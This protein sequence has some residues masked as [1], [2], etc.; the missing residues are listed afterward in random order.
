MCF[1]IPSSFCGIEVSQSWS[2]LYLFELIF[3]TYEPKRT[4]E[5]GTWR[6][7]ASLFM[8]FLAEAYGGDFVT[9]DNT[10]RHLESDKGKD[11]FR[12]FGVNF[13]EADIFEPKIITEIRELIEA[14][15][16]VFVYC[17]DGNKVNE[18]NIYARFLKPGDIIGVHDW[19][20]EITAGDLR[21]DVGGFAPIFMLECNKY[22]TQQA[23]WV[24]RN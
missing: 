24:K 16:R 23:F 11:L 17:D 14:P 12:R 19:M 3:K 6:G 20:E 7:G 9:Y 18:F 15:G 13:R 2:A 10:P 1:E 8:H 22:H 5:L 21:V 4:I